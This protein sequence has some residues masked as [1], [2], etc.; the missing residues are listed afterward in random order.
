M[1]PLHNACCLPGC[2]VAVEAMSAQAEAA[3]GWV[4]Q[5][6]STAHLLTSMHSVPGQHSAQAIQLTH[7]RA[8]HLLAPAGCAG[9]PARRRLR[10]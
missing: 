4:T 8:Q 3:I 6:C 5:L 1:P 9:R 2:T 7:D 10:V